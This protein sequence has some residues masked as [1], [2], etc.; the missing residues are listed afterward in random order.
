VAQHKSG[1]VGYSGTVRPCPQCRGTGSF[2]NP[3]ENRFDK[4]CSLCGGTKTV[5]TSR[6]CVCGR[7]I[8][9]KYKGYLICNDA[10]CFN[11]VNEI[12]KS[13]KQ[14]AEVERLAATSSSEAPYAPP[15]AYRIR[16]PLKPYN[17]DKN[18]PMTDEE[19]EDWIRDNGFGGFGK[20]YY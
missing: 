13:A 3:L 1:T 8:I 4:P 16:G 18:R 5:D 6:V 17:H 2:V 10:E 11:R 12:E 9:W 15:G 14:R 7:P 19:V 20:F